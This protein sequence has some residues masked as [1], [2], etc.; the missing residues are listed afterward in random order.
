MNARLERKLRLLAVIVFASVT[1]A[2]AYVLAQGYTS[3]TQ[4][5]VGI[6]YG[7]ILSL[8]IGG[9]T[10]FVLEGPMRMWLGGLSFTT[11]LVIR[12]SI[13]AAIIIPTQYFQL[14]AIIVGQPF[15]PSAK[16]SGAP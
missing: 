3:L 4:I 12:S 5:A 11:N 10:Q 13:Y 15:I 1:G 7:L 16:G 9:V 8:A 6:S 2:I 14:G